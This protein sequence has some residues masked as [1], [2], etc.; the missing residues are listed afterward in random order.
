MGT[1]LV[2]VEAYSSYAYPVEPRSFVVGGV[3]H[4]IRHLTRRWR[5]PGLIHFLAVIADDRTV[6]LIYDEQTDAWTLEE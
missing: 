4:K 6:R 2:R 3:E 5:T 1:E